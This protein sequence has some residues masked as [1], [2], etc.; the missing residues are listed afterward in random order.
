[1][2]VRVE[3]AVDARPSAAR[4]GP[5]RPHQPSQPI[6]CARGS[7]HPPCDR[8]IQLMARIVQAACRRRRQRVAAVASWR[9]GSGVTTACARTGLPRLPD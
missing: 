8:P 4:A 7:G 3:Q 6:T 1:M 9:T 5:L 2:S